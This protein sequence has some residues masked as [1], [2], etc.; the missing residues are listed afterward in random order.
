MRGTRSKQDQRRGYHLWLPQRGFEFSE[1]TSAKWI[2][3]VEIEK[4]RAENFYHVEKTKIMLEG[5]EK[6]L[7]DRL[8]PTFYKLV[9]IFPESTFHDFSQA[10]HQNIDISAK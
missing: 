7:I 10:P 3:N 4:F 5:H 8:R 6:L 2:L 1:G 9:F